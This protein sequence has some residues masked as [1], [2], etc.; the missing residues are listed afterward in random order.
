[1]RG[2]AAVD[3]I[4]MPLGLEFCFARVGISFEDW[5]PH[6]YYYSHAGNLHTCYLCLRYFVI[7]YL[8]TYS[9]TIEEKIIPCEKI[10]MCPFCA[11]AYLQIEKRQKNHTQKQDKNIG[12]HL[13]KKK[14][15]ISSVP[16]S[17][18]A[19]HLYAQRNHSL[20]CRIFVH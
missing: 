2:R 18:Y 16:T 14:R 9:S 6:N 17:I 4:A 15:N 8:H 12:R 7:L 3:T 19:F 5:L 10:S 11:H 20:C 1:M 13:K